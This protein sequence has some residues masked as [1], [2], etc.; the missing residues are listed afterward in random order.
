[1]RTTSTNRSFLILFLP[2]SDNIQQN[3]QHKLSPKFHFVPV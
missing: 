1:V 2:V 3:K